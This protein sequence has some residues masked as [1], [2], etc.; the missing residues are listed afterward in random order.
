[1]TTTKTSNQTE[2]LFVLQNLTVDSVSFAN[3]VTFSGVNPDA[4]G[5]VVT[6]DSINASDFKALFK[7][8]ADS[9]DLTDISSADLQY[10]AEVVSAATWTDLSGNYL[11]KTQATASAAS[12]N[13]FA[14]STSDDTNAK[15]IGDSSVSIKKDYVRYLA[16]K[17]TGSVHGADLFSN[18]AKLVQ[19]TD[20]DGGSNWDGIS[21][22]INTNIASALVDQNSYSYGTENSA[23]K[24]LMDTFL[25]TSAGIEKVLDEIAGVADTSDNYVE[26]NPPLETGDKVYIRVSV[27]YNNGT[28]TAG[29]WKNENDSDIDS[30]TIEVRPYLLEFVL[31]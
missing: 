18:E 8:K 28:D 19:D 31:Q 25:K 5:I 21:S 9:S 22:S 29:T 12:Q 14:N 26:F 13:N 7:V 30:R 16:E 3:N 1:M 4:S 11:G 27:D 15:L 20:A 23:C 24:D 17:I 10:K 6:V 2:G